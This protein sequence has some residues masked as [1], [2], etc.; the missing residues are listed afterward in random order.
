MKHTSALLFLCLAATTAPAAVHTVSNGTTPA[1]HA[2]IAAAMS[3]AADGDTIYICASHLS[4]GSFTV[5]KSLT[6]IGEGAWPVDGGHAATVGAITFSGASAGST[7]IGL[8]VDPATSSGTTLGTDQ[9]TI[10]RCRLHQVGIPSAY[11]VRTTNGSGGHVLRHNYIV[12]RIDLDNSAA[13]VLIA[14][15]IIAPWGGQVALRNSVEPT[16]LLRNNIFL[17]PVT[18][19]H[20]VSDVSNASFLSNIFMGTG[21]RI[22]EATVTSCLF[23]NNLTWQVPGI[24]TID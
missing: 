24:T 18:S 7:I 21:A 5:T 4:Y 17:G 13:D 23:N 6:L 11:A 14:N 15:N 1:Q 19:G 10:Q 2:T 22:N 16:V 3:A 8:F 9:I 12:G 20:S